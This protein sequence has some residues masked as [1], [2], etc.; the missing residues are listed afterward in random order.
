MSIRRT[1]LVGFILTGVLLLTSVYLQFGQGIMPCP[2]CLL[3]RFVFCLLFILFS[4]GLFAY[5]K[6]W[7]RLL[8]NSLTAL[9]SLLGMFL[10]GRQAWLQ[11]FPSANGSECGVSLQYMLQVLPMSKVIQKIFQG[12]AECSRRGFEFLS[13]NL[14]EWSFLWFTVF[15]LLGLCLLFEEFTS[16]NHRS[17]S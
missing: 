4:V 14:A 6:R 13:L 17:H 15:L 10:A 7:H 11:H 1:Y 9:I 2:L 12:S 16:N 8:I 3:Q 5:S